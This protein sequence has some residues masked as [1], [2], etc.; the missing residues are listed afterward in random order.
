[1][2]TH[3]D[4]ETELNNR[5]IDYFPIDIYIN[6]TTK[7]RHTCL[8]EHEFYM[9]P[10][11]ILRGR[12]CPTCKGKFLK[13][14]DTYK[15]ECLNLG[16]ECLS[17]EYKGNKVKLE[18]KHIICGHT[19]YTRPNDIISGYGCPNCNPNR[20][21]T[22]EEYQESVKDHFIVLEKYVGALTPILHQHIKCGEIRSAR[23]SDILYSVD[24]CPSCA[25]FGFDP[26]LPTILYH[27]SFEHESKTYYKIGITNKCSVQERFKSEWNIKNMQLIWEKLY[28]VGVEAKKMEKYLLSKYEKTNI[29]P[30]YSGNTEIITEL[31]PEPV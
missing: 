7:I 1:M 27:I 20:L 5:E 19:W 28:S 23:P 11:D 3:L 22:P 9:A 17:L 16:Y 30:L 25:K 31:V 24:S 12:G 6:K 15:G 4:Y 26:S 13:T 10:T 2:K 29:S 21:K 18:H 14:L 8:K